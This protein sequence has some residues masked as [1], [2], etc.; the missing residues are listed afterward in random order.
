MIG[1][2]TKSGGTGAL[3]YNF[4][5]GELIDTNLL[6]EDSK[7]II[8]KFK[9]VSSRN[10][11]VKNNLFHASLSLPENERLSKEKF[12]E[13]GHDYLDKMGFKNTPNAIFLHEDTKN[14]HIHI[15]ASRVK[16][17]GKVVKDFKD[18]H[19]SKKI[20]RQLEKK[21]D[22]EPVQERNKG[23]SKT[24]GEINANK[25]SRTC[26][27][28]NSLQ[29]H[30]EGVLK[31]SKTRKE[32]ENKCNDSI[33]IRPL[34]G[35][36]TYGIFGGGEEPFM[37]FSEKQLSEKYTYQSIN[38]HFSKI[39]AKKENIQKPVELPQ[40]IVSKPSEL[41]K[42]EHTIEITVQKREAIQKP[43]KEPLFAKVGKNLSKGLDPIKSIFA[44]KDKEKPREEPKKQVK[45]ENTNIQKPN[46][47]IIDEIDKILDRRDGLS[48]V[49]EHLDKYPLTTPQALKIIDN[50]KIDFTLKTV[51]L[52]IGG[53]QEMAKNLKPKL[54]LPQ[55][56]IEKGRKFQE[57][58]QNAPKRSKTQNNNK[59]YQI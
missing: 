53:K 19:K 24:L 52:E 39:E 25:Y 41:K 29:D 8:S 59:G 45:Q 33:Y 13:L 54:R 48:I 20:M 11:R 26:L 44:T 56:E 3:K 4:G 58:V 18:M 15:V 9:D 23:N 14:Q 28:K 35:K 43:K 55:S 31:E 47:D 49:R 40:K 30:L 16:F 38:E 37:Y 50:Q 1:K 22:L 10:S 12:R 32:Y 51:V 2:I 42:K 34:S 57:R 5:K 6:K 17:D 21:Y 46:K 27:L 7:Y 36:Y